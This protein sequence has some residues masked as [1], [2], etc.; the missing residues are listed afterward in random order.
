MNSVAPWPGPARASPSAVRRS[1]GERAWSPPV[2]VWLG[3]AG[4][5]GRQVQRGHAGEPVP[6]VVQVRGPRRAGEPVALP[7]GEV[8]VLHRAA[9][10]GGVAGRV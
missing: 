4:P 2:K 3:R 6:P 8:A 10:G 9:A 7:G 5:V 1:S